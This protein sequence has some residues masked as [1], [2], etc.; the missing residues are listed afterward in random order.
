M[1]IATFGYFFNKKEG[2][3]CPLSVHARRVS[4][5]YI[6]KTLDCFI[7]PNAFIPE[8]AQARGYDWKLHQKGVQT[9]EAM[10]NLEDFTRKQKVY[11]LGHQRTK[12]ALV[13]L[14]QKSGL[15]SQIDFSPLSLLL[16]DIQKDESDVEYFKRLSNPLTLHAE[17][18]ITLICE[19]V[20]SQKAH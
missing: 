5:G 18:D 9:R 13:G 14:Q 1:I 3:I 4:D 10:R 2:K 8:S 7:N 11:L 17:K 12:Q 15:T 19:H 20:K 16:N 6:I